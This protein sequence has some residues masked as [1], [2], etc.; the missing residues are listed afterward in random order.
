[1]TQYP[2]QDYTITV[3]STV[4]TATQ[5]YMSINYIV[6]NPQ[7]PVPYRLLDSSSQILWAGNALITEAELDNWGTDN[8]Y[9]VNLVCQQA[10]VTLI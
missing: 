7:M 9:I 10:G 6:G 5:I 4:Y 2:I 3:G 1:M 8:M